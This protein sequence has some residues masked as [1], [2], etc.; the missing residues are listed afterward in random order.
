MAVLLTG[1]PAL[2][3]RCPPS[4]GFIPACRSRNDGG[5]GRRGPWLSS[6][7]PGCERM[8]S[9]TLWVAV[10]TTDSSICSFLFHLSPNTPRTIL[11]F[12]VQ[13]WLR[14]V[15]PHGFPL[16][17]GRR[18]K[19]ERS[20]RTTRAGPLVREYRPQRKRG[21]NLLCRASAAA[22]GILQE[23]GRFDW[24]VPISQTYAVG[25]ILKPRR[26][27]GYRASASHRGHSLRRSP[28]R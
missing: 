4:N 7:D 27:L 16:P 15:S 26:R 5:R 3:G 11:S 25:T 22:H 18:K 24:S 12:F 8:N 6:V 21:G 20:S 14:E 2:H 23:R 19:S 13:D 10:A 17:A 1:P 28:P 9:L